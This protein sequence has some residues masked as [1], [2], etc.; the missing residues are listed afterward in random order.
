MGEKGN[1]TDRAED[2]AQNLIEQAPALL[3]EERRSRASDTGS[4]V[5]REANVADGTPHSAGAR[6]AARAAE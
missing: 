4:T 2:L 6:P 1:L 5:R 3:M